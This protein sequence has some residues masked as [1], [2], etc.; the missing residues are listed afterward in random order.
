MTQRDAA[1]PASRQR[2]GLRLTLVRHAQ[3]EPLT[4]GAED[5]ARALDRR[6]SADAREMARRC[7]EQGLVPDV[8]ISSPALRTRQTTDAFASV[9]ELDPAR[10]QHDPRLYLG[11]PAQLLAVLHE[12]GDHARHVMLVGHNPGISDFAQMLAPGARLGDFDTAATCTCVL[13]SDTWTAAGA[14]AV[15]DLRYDTP[16][17]RIG[18]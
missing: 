18:A 3:A 7:R 17:P 4:T 6:G 2:P 14:C 1:M 15:R 8:L 13:D 9:L 5:F 11:R 12:V 10:V 16:R